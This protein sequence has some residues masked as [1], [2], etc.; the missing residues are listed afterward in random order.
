[1][2]DMTFQLA[3]ALLSLYLTSVEAVCNV[4]VVGTVFSGALF[5]DAENL[6]TMTADNLAPVPMVDQF[7]MGVPPFGSAG[8][9]AEHLGFPSRSLNQWCAAA[10]THLFHTARVLGS[11]YATQGISLAVGFYSI[12]GQPHYLSNLF[13]AISLLTVSCQRPSLISGH[14]ISSSLRRA[15]PQCLMETRSAFWR[16]IGNSSKKIKPTEP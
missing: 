12:H 6:A 9:R 1:M 2:R 7:G 8:I 14:A 15:A 13:I 5:A 16:N 3:T 10:L 4:A 11:N